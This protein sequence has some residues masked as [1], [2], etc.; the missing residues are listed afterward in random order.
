M[1]DNSDISDINVAY[2]SLSGRY[3]K[4][5]LHIYPFGRLLTLMPYDHFF[6]I[7]YVSA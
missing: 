4:L 7:R 2:L 5:S 1:A 6:L 3:V